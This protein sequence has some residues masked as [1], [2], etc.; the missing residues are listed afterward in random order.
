MIGSRTGPERNLRG[1]EEGALGAGAGPDTCPEPG[2]RR[3]AAI[4][5]SA[6]GSSAVLYCG[7]VFSA[8]ST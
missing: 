5:A 3:L 2:F 7:I 1:G 4:R 8:L 6:C